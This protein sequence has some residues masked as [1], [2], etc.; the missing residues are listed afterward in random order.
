MFC[1]SFYVTRC[2]CFSSILVVKLF[3]A[4]SKHQKEMESKLNSAPTEAKKSKGEKM[5]LLVT[6]NH[7]FQVLATFFS[8][9]FLLPVCI[10]NLIPKY[11][12]YLSFL[13]FWC[14]YWLFVTEGI[15]LG[16]V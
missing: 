1:F 10:F 3:N 11:D 5:C 12:L 14:N 15:I 8:L 16:L 4:V 13:L 7:D 2:F 6:P 9:E